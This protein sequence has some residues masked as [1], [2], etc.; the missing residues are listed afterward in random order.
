M[1]SLEFRL[2]NLKESRLRAVLEAAAKK[3]GWG[4]KPAANHGYGLACGTEKGG[5][6]ATVAEVVVENDKPRVLRA[7][8]AFEC[9]AIINPDHLTNQIEGAVIM[10]LGGALS[11]AIEFEN[12][13]ITNPAFSAYKVPRFRDAPMLETVLID[14]KDLPSE[15]AGESP[16]IAIAP[17]V[18]NAIFE[19]TGKRVR[20]MPMAPKGKLA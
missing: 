4:A 10:G 15:G 1:D 17:A 6:V 12:G 16:I 7:V 2:K 11:E 9:G 13:Q 3:F 19:A 18:G 5:Y 8:T 14:R 20:S